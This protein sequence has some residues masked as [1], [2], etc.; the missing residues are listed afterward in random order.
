MPARS[1]RLVEIRFV[2]GLRLV[3]QYD[4]SAI[5]I[6]NLATCS[7]EQFLS[8]HITENFEKKFAVDFFSAQNESNFRVVTDSQ[9]NPASQ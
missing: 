4:T 3:S 2:F 1:L 8:P 9:G 6:K 5:I 7:E